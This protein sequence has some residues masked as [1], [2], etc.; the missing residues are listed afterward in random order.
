MSPELTDACDAQACCGEPWT[1]ER[2]TCPA[3]EPV[4]HAPGADGSLGDDE[5]AVDGAGH[6]WRVTVA[7]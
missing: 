3:E 5:L 6:V 7:D 4:D 1:C 2:W